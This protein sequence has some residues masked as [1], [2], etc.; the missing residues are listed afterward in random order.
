MFAPVIKSK[1]EIQSLK[2]E[3]DSS[4]RKLKGSKLVNEVCFWSLWLR[5]FGSFRI[6]SF[7]LR[8]SRPAGLRTL[9]LFPFMTAA[10]L[11]VNS[12]GRSEPSG[13]DAS[14]IS[15]RLPPQLQQVR[16]LLQGKSP[17]DVRKTII[18]HFGPAQ[19]DVGSG[20][21]IEQWDVFDGVLTFNPAVGPQFTPKGQRTIHLIT[22][23]NPVR[24]NLLGSYEMLSLPADTNRTRFWLGNL[25]IKPNLTYSYKDSRQF[26]EK[27]AQQASNFFYRHPSGT[28]EIKY[29]QGV[30]D[31]TL[32]ETLPTD[33]VVAW[34]HFRAGD[35]DG[36]QTFTITT[37]E[38]TRRLVFGAPEPLSFEMDKSWEEFW[39]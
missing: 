31:E 7:V 11:T 5:I 36:E 15:L 25:R 26:P 3:T 27:S 19:R 8:V 32:L 21:R 39:K 6:S 38:P 37:R 24:T 2:S 22:T 29:A 23:H 17:E 9:S 4:R 34:L 33:S 30:T 14:G 35:G 20:L 28:V 16:S 12:I 1:S 10:I 13:G 18:D